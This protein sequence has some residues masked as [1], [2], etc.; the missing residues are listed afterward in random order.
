MSKEQISKRFWADMNISTKIFI[1][2]V[3]ILVL[4]FFITGYFVIN[5]VKEHFTHEISEQLSAEVKTIKD[6]LNSTDKTTQEIKEEIEENALFDLTERAQALKSTITKLYS[7]YTSVGMTPTVIK[8]QLSTEILQTRI[9]TSGYA[10]AL[11]SNGTLVV[12]P[13]KQGTNLKGKKHIDQMLEEKNGVIVYERSTDPNHPKVYA[14][15][16]YLPQLDWIIV[17]TIP[18]NE[19]MEIANKVQDEILND[20]KKSIKTLK[21]GKTGYYYIMNSKGLLVVH[22]SKKFEGKSVYKYDFAKEMI[23]NKN[24]VIRYKWEGKYKIVAYTYYAPRDWIIAGGSY[25]DEFLGHI[26]KSAILNFSIVSIIVVLVLLVVLRLVFK[27]NVINPIDELEGLF[28]KIASGDLTQKLAVKRKNEIG[29]IIINVNNM[30]DQM[31]KALCEVNASTKDVG[32]SA[33]VLAASSNQM[34]SGADTQAERISSVEVAMQE[35]TA[36]ITEISQ[37]LEEVSNEIEGIKG[38]A[39]TGRQVIDETVEGITNLS[40]TVITSAEKMKELGKSSEQIGE[41]LQV[42][43]DIADQTNLLALNAAIEAARAGEHGRGFAVVADEVRKLAERTAKA[44]G[45]IDEMIKSIQ[46]EVKSSVVHMDKG[47][48]LAEEGSMLVGNLKMSLEE[49][50]N[51]VLDVADK[52]TAVASAVDQQSATSQEI[53]NNMAEIATIAQE[54]T[55]IAQE[56]HNQAEMLKELAKKLQQIVNEFKLQECESLK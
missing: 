31:N 54:N 10:Y 48:R 5:N 42:I 45:E 43:S 30:I 28:Q 49:I 39:E 55:S 14:A 36:T 24:G 46:S 18:E 37:N 56:N 41:I 40:E 33:E 7:T 53:L 51:G 12:H 34:T 20:I 19:L 38:A 1:F 17:L 15:F 35:M 44:T 16:R 9:G 29:R 32:Q 21:I 8:F 22:P 27:I 50:I 13:T 26:V 3:L 25:E 11:D 47:A 4:G 6:F 23:K 52:I 2:L